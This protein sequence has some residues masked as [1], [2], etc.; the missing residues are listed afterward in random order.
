[1][2]GANGIQMQVHPDFW[3]LMKDIK[4]DRVKEGKERSGKL[5]DK[6][7]SLTIFKLFKSRIDLYNLIINA[8]IDLN[9][10]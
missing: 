8:E 5:S 6:R 1:M 2:K 9:E 10:V 3:K 7:L 4:D